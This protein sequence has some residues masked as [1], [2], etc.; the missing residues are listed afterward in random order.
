M[1]G[2]WSIRSLEDEMTWGIHEL[3]TKTRAWSYP[4][5]LGKNVNHH[6]PQH[7]GSL[8]HIMLVYVTCRCM[9]FGPLNK[10]EQVSNFPVGPCVRTSLRPAPPRTIPRGGMVFG[11][12]FKS[13]RVPRVESWTWTNGSAFSSYWFRRSLSFVPS[14]ILYSMS[15]YI[16]MGAV[17]DQ[18]WGHGIHVFF[19]FCVQFQGS[20]ERSCGKTRHRTWVGSAAPQLAMT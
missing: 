9:S 15:Y 11:H 1:T 6:T 7:A 13:L 19:F 14:P 12:F 20:S 18:R 17:S 4:R 3:T 2:D 5:K 8:Y 10:P 16:L